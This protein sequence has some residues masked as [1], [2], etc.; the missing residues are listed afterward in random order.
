MFSYTIYERTCE[1]TNNSIKEGDDVIIPEYIDGYKV[2][3]IGE[4]A[5]SEGIYRNITLPDTVLYIKYFA[6][7]ACVVS[8]TIHFPKYLK[9]IYNNAFW[10]CDVKS[11]T[12]PDSLEKIGDHTFAN[13]TFSGTLTIPENVH[14]IGYGA[15]TNGLFD[16]LKFKTDKLKTIQPYTFVNCEN[17]SK[18][19]VFPDSLR[20]I[21]DR[22]FFNCGIENTVINPI[23]DV[24][25]DAFKWCVKLS[26]EYKKVFERTKIRA[27]K[28]IY[29]WIIQRLYRPGSD[30]AKRLAEASWKATLKDIEEFTQ[31]Y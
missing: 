12:L 28:L 15:F 9:K 14:F 6:F 22:A 29:F 7:S 30:S 18:T 21:G 4:S 13:C 26:P 2:T 5:F 27:Q 8:G 11:I 20:E 10:F 23:V 25:E 3:S 19:V 31:S 17:L 16:V 1:I 24:H